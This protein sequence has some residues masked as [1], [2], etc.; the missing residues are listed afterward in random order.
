MHPS[1]LK[2]LK[3]C[4]H[5]KRPITFLV[6]AGISAESGIPTFR[7][8]DGYW[9]VG[10]KNYKA[11]EIGTF[12]M[13]SLAAKEVWKWYLYRKSVTHRALPNESH[14]ALVRIEKL[15]GSQYALISQNVD[16][17]HRRA[18]SNEEQTY[19]I[20]GDFDFVR[21]ASECTKDL[22]PFPS[23]INLTN[24]NK[25]VITPEEWDA[26]TC[27]NC[28]DD[29]RPHVLWF[30]EYYN[31]EYYKFD[32]ALKT[33]EK[34]HILFILGTSGATTLPQ[35]IAERVISRGGMVIDVNINESYFS[36]LLKSH[37]NGIVINSKSTPFLLELE[38]E[39]KEIIY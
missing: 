16:S 36:Q 17:L 4:I 27:P 30:D 23:S 13:F 12:R 19:L 20:H 26:L 2:Q 8:K 38:N 29:L 18:G 3:R 35:M 6:G 34:S 11:E 21:C 14:K 1:I 31:E 39:L 9:T 37:E 33:A 5:Q 10:S 15:I 32:S 28:G 7:G 22:Y 24:R 25:N